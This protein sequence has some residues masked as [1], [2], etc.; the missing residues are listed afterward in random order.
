MEVIRNIAK[1]FG[2]GKIEMKGRGMRNM[3]IPHPLAEIF[4]DWNLA[5]RN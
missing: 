3:A 4:K 1:L 5:D 2:E